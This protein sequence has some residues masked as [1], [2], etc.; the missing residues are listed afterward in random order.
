MTGSAVFSSSSP[1][2]STAVAKSKT[3]MKTPASR[4][5]LAPTPTHPSTCPR[6]SLFQR[7]F[8]PV[9][10]SGLQAAAAASPAA[11]SDTEFA[12]V[13]ATAQ[14]PSTLLLTHAPLH[15]HPPVLSMFIHRR[16]PSPIPRPCIHPMPTILPCSC[17]HPVRRIRRQFLLQPGQ[18]QVVWRHEVHPGAAQGPVPGHPAGFPRVGTRHGGPVGWCGRRLVQVGMGLP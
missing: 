1:T 18:L 17:T 12:Q 10:A 6:P 7:V 14:L 4:C 5:V 16:S 13:P 11:I 3:T 8:Q 9:G 2:S 15:A